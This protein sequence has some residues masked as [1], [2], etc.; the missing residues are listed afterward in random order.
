MTKGQ[1][2]DPFSIIHKNIAF[3]ILSILIYTFARPSRQ[4]AG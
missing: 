4:Q 3:L 1:V 2:S